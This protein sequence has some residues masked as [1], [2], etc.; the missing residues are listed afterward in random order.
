M[1]NVSHAATI[2]AFTIDGPAGC[3]HK[4]H[5]AYHDVQVAA[6]AALGAVTKARWQRLTLTQRTAGMFAVEGFDADDHSSGTYLLTLS[7]GPQ[8]LTAEPPV[9]DCRVTHA[10]ATN[11]ASSEPV[12]APLVHH[13]PRTPRASWADWMP[14]IPATLARADV[15]AGLTA[16]VAP[17]I[18]PGTIAEWE[19]EGILPMPNGAPTAASYPKEA[20]R[21]I[22]LLVSLDH[23]GRTHLDILELLKHHADELNTHAKAGADQS[24]GG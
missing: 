14:A 4:T 18:Q 3:V 2:D 23:T 1:P 21:I 10:H 11:R 13:R 17:H 22:D 19:R 16:T 5:V 7:V 15:I 20:S 8:P 24:N 9:R 12:A 6:W